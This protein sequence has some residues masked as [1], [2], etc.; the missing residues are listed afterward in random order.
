MQSIAHSIS[1]ELRT[2]LQSADFRG[3]LFDGSEDITKTKQEICDIVSVSSSGEFTPDFIGLIELDADRTAQA[4][5]DALVRLFQDLDD[6]TTNRRGCCQRRY[7]QERCAKTLAAA[8]DSLEHILCTAHT[9]E[10]CAKAAD[11]NFPY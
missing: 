2:K 11:R 5:T 9:L 8:G 6:W 7:L 1:R 3:L 4:I 10:N